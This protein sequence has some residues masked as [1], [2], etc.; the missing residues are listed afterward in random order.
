MELENKVKK[1][2]LNCEDENT[3]DI[4]IEVLSKDSEEYFNNEEN[5]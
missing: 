5:N 2:L 3:M 1:K 4:K